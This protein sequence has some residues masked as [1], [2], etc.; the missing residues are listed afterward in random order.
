[1][2]SVRVLHGSEAQQ[3]GL[4]NRLK[5]TCITCVQ[6]G[7]GEGCHTDQRHVSEGGRWTQSHQNGLRAEWAAG[8]V[9]HG[10]EAQQG[11][12]GGRGQKCI[13]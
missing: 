3:E 4:D 11:E 12:G 8:G 1:M 2:T 5:V 9:L 6:S 10:S 13:C 7:Q